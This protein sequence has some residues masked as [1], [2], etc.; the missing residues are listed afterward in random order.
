M[1]ANHQIT[2]EI[3]PDILLI[4]KDYLRKT[5]TT[6]LLGSLSPRLFSPFRCL[7]L[8]PSLFI[9]ALFLLAIALVRENLRKTNDQ[10]ET[11]S[12]DVYGYV[13]VCQKKSPL[14][15]HGHGHGHG[16]HSQ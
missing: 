8:F 2:A 10:R 12:M 6:S 15:S 9:H 11:V 4:K 1:A 3:R 14:Q 7:H 5:T 13:C 16:Q